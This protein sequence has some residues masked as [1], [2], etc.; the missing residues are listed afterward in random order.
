MGRQR[1]TRQWEA[2]RF[3]AAVRRKNK[4]S[5]AEKHKEFDSNQASG[6]DNAARRH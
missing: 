3:I 4:G 2:T 1:K 6:T 5:R